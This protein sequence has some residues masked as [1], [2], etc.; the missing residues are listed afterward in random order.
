MHYTILTHGTAS[1]YD[2]GLGL[3]RGLAELGI[4]C[5]VTGRFIWMAARRA[6][7]QRSVCI[8]I[9]SWRSLPVIYDQPRSEGAAV[10]AWLVSDDTVTTEAARRLNDLD[11]FYVTSAWCKRTFEEAGVQPSKML[12]LPEGVDTG[13]WS[14][15]GTAR[16]DDWRNWIM[17][18]WRSRHVNRAGARGNPATEWDRHVVAG[19]AVR[20]TARRC[21]YGRHPA[22]HRRDRQ[23]AGKSVAGATTDRRRGRD[24]KGIPGGSPRTGRHR[25]CEC[26][27]RRQDQ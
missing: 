23:T 2:Q 11:W 17:P 9:G 3:T 15:S 12:V 4:P 7:R 19:E 16:L 22:Q 26:D 27:L 18:L 21:T 1:F 13:F 5:R 20:P 6:V 10:I 25:S 24:L 14:P 8:G